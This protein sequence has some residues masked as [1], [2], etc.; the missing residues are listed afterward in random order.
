MPWGPATSAV[1]LSWGMAVHALGAADAIPEAEAALAAARATPGGAATPVEFVALAALSA[2]VQWR[3]G[4]LRRCE[5][6]AAAGLAALRMHEPGPQ[7]DAM[8][9]ALLR[10]GVLVALERGEVEEAGA[11]LTSMT[12]VTPARASRFNACATP[13]RRSRWPRRARGDVARGVPAARL[14]AAA[15][16]DNPTVPWRLLAGHALL[17]LDRP[18]EADQLAAAAHERALVWGGA[19]EIAG[20]LRLKARMDE[21]SRVALL[22]EAVARLERAPA[23][24]HLAAALCDLGDALR[25]QRRPTEAREPLHRGADLAREIGATALTRRAL[26]SLEMLGERRRTCH[27]PESI[28]SPPASA[29]SPA[30]TPGVAPTRHRPGAVRDAEDGREPPRPRLLQARR[31]RAAGADQ[32]GG[33]ELTRR[34]CMPSVVDGHD[35]RRSGA[36]SRWRP[37]PWRCH[38]RRSRRR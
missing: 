20:A 34:P 2:Q 7:A 18:E 31:R 11:L 32:H 13:T 6:E 17:R 29:A 12:S 36:R 25:V 35:L 26:D 33:R 15:R 5:S 14:R 24:L 16:A 28:R 22:E 19:A 3:A 38:R 37:S 8:T 4:D 27:G 9:A 30:S 10:F 1:V 23:R 21:T